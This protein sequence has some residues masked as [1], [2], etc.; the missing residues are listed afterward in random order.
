[1]RELALAVAAFAT[2]GLASLATLAEG[3]SNSETPQVNVPI[4]LRQANWGRGSNGSC[5]HASLVTAL[6]WQGQP[7]LA[8]QWRR[9]HSGGENARSLPPKL[10]AAGIRYVQTYNAGDV[11]FL[12]WSVATRRGCMV[13]VNGFTHAVFLAHLDD[14]WAGIIGTN[15]PETLIWV[16]R[17]EFLEDWRKS[18]SWAI[19]VAYTPSPPLATR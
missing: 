17:E 15:F 10:D 18:R 13:A 1:M 12:E 16:D 9:S 6:R 3:V 4:A 7:I 11:A 19:A 5:A 8:E 2:I 14:R